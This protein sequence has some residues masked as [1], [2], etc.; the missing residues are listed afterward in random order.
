MP[1]VLVVDD[2]PDIRTLLRIALERS[3]GLEVVAVGSAVEAFA[4]L[5]EGPFDLVLLDVMMPGMDGLGVLER[6]RELPG[7]EH[8]AVAFLTARTQDHDLERYR[9]AGVVDVLTKPFEPQ[10]LVERVRELAGGA[11]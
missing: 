4:A 10:A 1:R 3:P 6:L 5:G 2:E 7:G 8:L 11:R 9:A